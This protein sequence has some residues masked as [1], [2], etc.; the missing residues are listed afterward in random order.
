MHKE[1]SMSSRQAKFWYPSKCWKDTH[2]VRDK[3]WSTH[4]ATVQSTIVTHHQH[5]TLLTQSLVALTVRRNNTA[6]LLLWL[7][8]RYP[9]MRSWGMGT[10][11]LN[12]GIAV[13][14]PLW[15]SPNLLKESDRG[16][17]QVSS[18]RE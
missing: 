7:T 10:S 11:F 15:M 9:G 12:E 6:A 3:D 13:L 17:R 4:L 2:T 16:N 1:G 14:K 18:C 8:L 5:G